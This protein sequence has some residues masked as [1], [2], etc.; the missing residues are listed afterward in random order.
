MARRFFDCSV[1]QDID[2]SAYNALIAAEIERLRLQI[3]E[4][5]VCKLAS[6]LNDGKPCTIEHPSRVV[7]PGALMG[8][9]NYHTR[10]RFYNG[11]MSWLMRVPRTL[12]FAVGLPIS[13]AEYL[14]R[15]EYATLKFLE[16]TAVPAPRAFA[17]GI[18]S[19]NTDHGVGVPFLFIE[20]MPGKPW[21]G[22]GDASKVWHG[23]ATILAELERYPFSK[24]GSL[25]VESPRDL[26]SVSAVASD[27]FV[28]AG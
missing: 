1:S 23:L 20:E 25:Y 7:G 2:D 26:P 8:C 14:I 9:A 28:S 11:S 4:K 21:D 22:R 24:A 16:T 12:G 19:E 13:L 27:R 5:A 10:I 15:S 18:P 3:N 17:F 6:S